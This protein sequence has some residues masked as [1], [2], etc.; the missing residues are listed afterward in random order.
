MKTSSAPKYFVISSV[1]QESKS[2]IAKATSVDE[3][4]E[5]VAKITIQPSFRPLKKY[6]KIIATK[7]KMRRR[8]ALYCKNHE[9]QIRQQ[10]C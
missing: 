1:P 8:K 5:R 7:K 2:K 3:M 6:K 4:I 9:L 10:G